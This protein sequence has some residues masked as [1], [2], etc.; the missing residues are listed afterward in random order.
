M[1]ARHRSS[2]ALVGV[3]LLGALVVWTPGA[4]AAHAADGAQLAVTI[5]GRAV[6]SATEQR[7]IRLDPRR[8]ATLRVRVTNAG[9]APLE[10]TTVRLRGQVMALSFFTYDTSVGVTVAPGA[11][12]ERTFVVDLVGLG[13]QATG[14]VQGSV[15]VLDPARRTLASQPMVVDIRGSMRSVYGLFG[16]AVALLTAVSLTGALVALGSHRLPDNRWRRGLR[17]LTP[18]LGCGLVVVFT[19]SALRVFVPRPGR[20]IPIL[21]VSG[22]ALFVAGYLTPSPDGE[23]EDDGEDRSEDDDDEGESAGDRRTVA[24]PIESPVRPAPRTVGGSA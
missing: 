1:T 15:S 16:L 4:P 22:I 10:V 17:F 6:S 20:W 3:A 9:D 13:G 11:T 8:P 24:R 21:L 14:L 18:G 7:P 23:D 5:D 2:A 12:E 19:L